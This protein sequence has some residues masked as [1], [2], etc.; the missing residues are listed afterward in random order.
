MEAFD[1]FGPPSAL[2]TVLEA[3]SVH[4]GREIKQGA[5]ENFVDYNE[6]KFFDLSQLN[7]RILQAQ[8]DCFGAVLTPALQTATQFFP[9]GGQNED[10]D[11]VGVHP[12]NLDGAL[13][14]NFQNDVGALRHA[15]FQHLFGSAIAVAVHVR[16]FHKGVG[17]HHGIKLLLRHKKVFSTMFFLTAGRARGVRHRG[18]HAGVKLHQG[19]DQAG[20]ARTTGGG[21]DVEV[22]RIFHGKECNGV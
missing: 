5:I 22:S 2:C 10:E 14:I 18:Q 20:L 12:F 6:V 1:S 21:Y 7:G 17:G 3:L 9:A 15:L 8:F 4:D 13:V 19:F 11:G 16:P